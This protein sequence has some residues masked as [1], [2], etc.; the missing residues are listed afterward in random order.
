MK[1]NKILKQCPEA[2]SFLTKYFLVSRGFNKRI[3]YEKKHDR[4]II[5]L[6]NGY[7]NIK[8]ENIFP[9]DSVMDIPMIGDV[10]Y[11]E[12]QHFY[13]E[14]KYNNE[15]IK[16]FGIISNEPL[17]PKETYWHQEEYFDFRHIIKCDNKMVIITYQR[18]SHRGIFRSQPCL[19]LSYY[20]DNY[21]TNVSHSDSALLDDAFSESCSFYKWEKYRKKNYSTV[22]CHYYD[23][24]AFAEIYKEAEILLG[25]KLGYRIDLVL[26]YLKC[27]RD[28]INSYSSLA[29]HSRRISQRRRYLENE[30]R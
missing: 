4:E 24:C 3:S 30:R 29:E 20:E 1:E 11:I 18:P 9:Y 7:C 23:E 16:S 14:E 13:F 6:K 17:N 26:K 12:P 10:K 5:C 2:E 28:V 8:L 15:D 19:Q 22:Y 25:I 27:K 21:Y